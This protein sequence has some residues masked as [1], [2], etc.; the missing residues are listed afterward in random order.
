MNHTERKYRMIQKR[1][2][3]E[4][5]AKLQ[6]GSGRMPLEGFINL[7][8][9]RLPGTDVVADLEKSLP[10]EDDAF[11]LVYS[12]HT[13][14][15]VGNTLGLLSEIHRIT[16]SSGRIEIEV[17]HPSYI[18]MFCDPTHKHFF[19]LHSF[20]YFQ[21]K[22]EFDFYT[23]VRFKILRKSVQFTG[24]RFKLFN[25]ISSVVNICSFTQDLWERFCWWLPMENLFII[26]QPVKKR[27]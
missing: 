7:D 19:T 9:V 20:D 18:F 13:L 4:K 21:E 15:H 16:K 1:M 14:E 2:R 12:R 25:L 5:G 6:L 24:G 17:P 23:S 3:S 11:D 10:F 8:V 26:L 22:N 27:G